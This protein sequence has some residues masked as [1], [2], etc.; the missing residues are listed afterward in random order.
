MQLNLESPILNLQQKPFADP[1]SAYAKIFE[2]LI[3]NISIDDI[4]KFC[5]EQIETNI[6]TIKSA[7][8]FAVINS[9]E[10]K[11]TADDSYKAYKLAKKIEDGENLSID[12]LAKIKK[13]HVG[14]VFK[15]SPEVL[16]YIWDFLENQ[17]S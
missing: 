3:K 7:L 5:Q 2:M 12:E 8:R 6:L 17:K 4:K 16:G 10:D 9:K 11:K 13:D 15:Y 1:D 14:E